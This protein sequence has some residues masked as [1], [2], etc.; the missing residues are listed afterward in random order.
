MDRMNDFAVIFV[1]GHVHIIAEECFTAS[2]T[3]NNVKINNFI[4]EYTWTNLIKRN[5]SFRK[6]CNVQFEAPTEV[7]YRLSCKCFE[8]RT[9]NYGLRRF[10]SKFTFI[11]VI[12]SKANQ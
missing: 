8:T 9:L 7:T 2:M 6:G 4:F 11:H 12:W 3:V 10:R 5:A 1:P